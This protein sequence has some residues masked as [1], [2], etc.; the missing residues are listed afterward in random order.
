MTREEQIRRLI[1]TKS[2]ACLE[3]NFDRV[4]FNKK[5]WWPHRFALA[6][7]SGENR[8]ASIARHSCGNKKCVNPKHL[9]W[10]GPTQMR[11][12]ERENYIRKTGRPP[13]REKVE[14]VA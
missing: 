5:Q 14:V 1:E 11:E 7:F 4:T 6:V 2:D 9:Y 8:L 13:A 3:V 12:D 10:D